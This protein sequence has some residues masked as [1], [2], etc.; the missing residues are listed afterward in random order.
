MCCSFIGQTTLHRFAACQPLSRSDASR[1]KNLKRLS[2]KTRHTHCW[3]T[4]LLPKT[5]IIVHQI[6]SISNYYESR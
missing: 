3:I 1:K 4:E 6:T 5:G 2:K